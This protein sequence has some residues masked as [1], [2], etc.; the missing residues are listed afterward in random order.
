MEDEVEGAAGFCFGEFGDSG[1]DG[2]DG[3]AHASQLFFVFEGV[4]VLDGLVDDDVVGVLDLE[5]GCR[6]Q[7]AGD[8][9]DL[10]GGNGGCVVGEFGLKGGVFEGE[11]VVADAGDFAVENDPL[12]DIFI[13]VALVVG[14]EVVDFPCE[15][16]PGSFGD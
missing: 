1:L 2:D 12:S 13:E 8:V 3:T 9:D 10:A 4:D 14:F 7:E 16:G 11:G 6:F 5:Q 15:F